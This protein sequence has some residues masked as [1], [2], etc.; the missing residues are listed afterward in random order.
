M[1]ACAKKLA[2]HLGAIKDFIGY[3]HLAR[4]VAFPG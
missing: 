3:D 4:A 2:T 1:L